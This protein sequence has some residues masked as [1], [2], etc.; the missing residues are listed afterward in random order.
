VLPRSSPNSQT[1]A[2]RRHA[3]LRAAAQSCGRGFNLPAAYRARPNS[4]KHINFLWIGQQRIK[5][6]P[7][8]L[9]PWQVR[10]W[11]PN[12]RDQGIHS[13]EEASVPP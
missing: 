4:I 8:R 3:V 12:D 9:M 13:I 11:R 2:S 1:T 5:Y 6:R 10:L 7:H